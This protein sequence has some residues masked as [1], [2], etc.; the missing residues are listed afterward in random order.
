MGLIEK[1][2]EKFRRSSTSSAPVEDDTSSSSSSSSSGDEG[3][4]FGATPRVSK[5]H[6]GKNYQV[7]DRAKFK[8]E[9]YQCLVP[10]TS[11][12]LMTPAGDTANWMPVTGTGEGAGS[13][14]PTPVTPQAPVT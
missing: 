4:V 3:G 5:W 1:V 8:G 10:H 11:S 7:G 13:F 14:T 6:S 2:K 9:V 12:K